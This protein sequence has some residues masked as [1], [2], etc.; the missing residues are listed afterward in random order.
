M[1]ARPGFPVRGQ[2]G[3]PERARRDDA[4]AWSR[5]F[6]VGIALL[7]PLPATATGSTPASH[8]AW[9][10]LSSMA[11]GS[12]PLRLML[13]TSI[14]PVPATAAVDADNADRIVERQ[15]RARDVRAVA[16]AVLV[17]V[18]GAGIVHAGDIRIL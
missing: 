14:W 18:T 4:D 12:V 7:P 10:A 2:P 17:P 5:E 8:A 9:K 3:D 16:A 6:D 15:D 1:L 13:T 11:L